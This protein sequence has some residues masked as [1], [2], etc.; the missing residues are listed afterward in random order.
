[1]PHESKSGIKAFT[2]ELSVPLHHGSHARLDVIV[3]LI[4]RSSESQ[5]RKKNKECY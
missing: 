3:N 4:T 5:G 2:W 1:M